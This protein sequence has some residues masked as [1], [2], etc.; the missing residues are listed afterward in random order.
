[1]SRE[2]EHFR[3]WFIFG[4]GADGR[5]DISDGD[6]DVLEGVGRAAAEQIIDARDVWLA[7]AERV[8]ALHPPGPVE[9]VERC[10]GEVNTSKFLFCHQMRKDIDS[11]GIR[12][13]GWIRYV[14]KPAWLESERG[15]IFKCPFCGET[16]RTTPISFECVAD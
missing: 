10:S 4:E 1:M 6:R 13:D 9:L 5:V 7:E 12:I 14:N 15:L 16:L 8:L 11:G 3:A 2:R